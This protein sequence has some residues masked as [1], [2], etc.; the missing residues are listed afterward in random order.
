MVDGVLVEVTD[1]NIVAVGVELPAFLLGNAFAVQPHLK[2]FAFD[3]VS[4]I[5]NN[6][7]DV[8]PLL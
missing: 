3:L 6:Q 8:V 2:F 4:C 1:T 5:T 7:T